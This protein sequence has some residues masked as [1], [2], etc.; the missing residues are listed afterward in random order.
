MTDVNISDFYPESTQTEQGRSMSREDGTT[1]ADIADFYGI[2]TERTAPLQRTEDVPFVPHWAEKM[3]DN[4]ILE[5]EALS[6]ALGGK[7]A[8]EFIFGDSVRDTV[9]S[10]DIGKSSAVKDKVAK[11]KKY[12][13]EGETK[14]IP[15]NG[16]S[17]LVGRKDPTSN[18]NKFGYVTDELLPETASLATA[19]SIAGEAIGASRIPIVGA[20]L[21]AAGGFLAG[22]ALDIGL[23]SLRGYKDGDKLVSK[24]T[25]LGAAANAAF[26]FIGRGG[27]IGG[28]VAKA[29]QPKKIPDR[30]KDA[31]TFAEKEGLPDVMRGQATANPQVEAMFG[32]VTA[33]NESARL[34]VIEQNIQATQKYLQ[35]AEKNGFAG[36][37][38]KVLQGL[39]DKERYDLDSLLSGIK[40]KEISPEQASQLLQGSF[41]NWE[42]LVDGKG[43]YLD[44]L[45]KKAIETSDD[46]AFDLVGPQSLVVEM[47][48]GVVGRGVS[49]E[50]PSPVVGPDGKPL[51]TMTA[52]PEIKITEDP[53]GALGQAMDALME[54][55]PVI[56]GYNAK[57]GS[58]FSSFEQIK[59]LRTRFRRLGESNDPGVA[60]PAK[61]IHNALTDAMEKG[62]DISGDP[63]K[64]KAFQDAWKQASTQYRAF[65]NL[66]E[67]KVISKI[68]D[69][70]QGDYYQVVDG[71]MRPG[72]SEALKLI[73]SVVPEGQKLL[74]KVFVTKLLAGTRTSEWKDTITQELN[75]FAKA[76]DSST[77]DYLLP[78]HERETLIKF[79]EG[80]NKLEGSFLSNIS[81]LDRESSST[82]WEAIT[83]GSAED[84]KYIVDL[85][86][87]VGSQTG[88]SLVRGVLTKLYQMTT[89]NVPKFG[90]AFM[91]EKFRDELTKLENKGIT[92]LLFSKDQMEFLKNLDK[93]VDTVQIKAD[94]GSSLQ[95]GEQAGGALRYTVEAPGAITEG[96]G[97]AKTMKVMKLPVAT[98]VAGRF[99]AEPA[100]KKFGLRAGKKVSAYRWASLGLSSMLGQESAE[101][102]S[103]FEEYDFISPQPI[104]G[105]F[106]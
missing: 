31:M 12:Y 24:D 50:V 51:G 38:K 72:K 5:K 59:E 11:F 76:N 40:S 13:P 86:G 47:R 23:E 56:T 80:M 8:S 3:Y 65:N 7:Y 74:Q 90:E 87:G 48:D 61:R 78:Q 89:K 28:I 68:T 1:S 98:A 71:L 36:V 42:R 105:A 45:Y 79:S 4:K 32:Q 14:Q 93:Y 104:K 81:K 88:Q 34:K 106:E 35:F 69:M 97:L 33:I 92:G 9:L 16:K 95:A 27:A 21:G 63:V 84:L 99:L 100:Q 30:V 46:I 58:T 17:I 75:K 70:E 66:S 44:S 54:L 64:T 62:T 19:G 103:T 29:V 102:P 101:Q 43:G 83:T 53:Q 91:Y 37:D 67:L 60:G 26:S 2:P 82:A 6:S 55:N 41:E 57:N 73:G 15:Y 94:M 25:A 39:I 22:K 20:P 85:A 77:I 52:T 96:K 10:T 49:R 18:W